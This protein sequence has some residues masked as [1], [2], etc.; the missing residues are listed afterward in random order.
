MEKRLEYDVTVSAR[1][2][3]GRE[4]S[5]SGVVVATSGS[6]NEVRLCLEPNDPDCVQF[7]NV[8]VDGAFNYDM[9]FPEGYVMMNSPERVESSVIEAFLVDAN[10]PGDVTLGKVGEIQCP[11]GAT[12]SSPGGHCNGLDIVDS[13]SVLNVALSSGGPIDVFF[14]PS[15]NSNKKSSM[16]RST[17][18]AVA[19]SV[20]SRQGFSLSSQVTIGTKT[21]GL[22]LESLR[23]E[24]LSAYVSDS[25]VIQ[26]TISST[27]RT[28]PIR[29]IIHPSCGGVRISGGEAG[30]Q[31]GVRF[32]ISVS[33]SGADGF[34]TLS[35]TD[36]NSG[37]VYGV[38]PPSIRVT[39]ESST[40]IVR[41]FLSDPLING[42]FKFS[43]FG[44]HSC[45]MDVSGE[46]TSADYDILRTAGVDGVV[47]SSSSGSSRTCDGAFSL[48]TCGKG[49]SWTG[50]IRDIMILSLI[51][52][53]AIFLFK[54]VVY[55]M[56]KSRKSKF[57]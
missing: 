52:F 14:T 34:G 4:I 49:I 1:F 41:V 27:L 24:E 39:S 18:D 25:P 5:S 44:G 33:S 36:L 2:S 19:T 12:P 15:S 42:E 9:D 7:I 37:D 17:S 51:A 20:A 40:Q 38:V 32:E 57:Q 26:T 30:S 54:M 46:V 22:S 16:F 31:F 11:R 47:L 6:F 50:W 48:I 53:G 8:N 55:P 21:F 35:F 3:D 43:S 13:N 29:T 28:Q 45:L 23:K 10:A 56:L